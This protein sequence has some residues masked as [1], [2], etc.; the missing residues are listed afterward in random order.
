M[1]ESKVRKLTFFLKMVACTLSGALLLQSLLPAAPARAETID[2]PPGYKQ[3]ESG[4]HMT[5]ALD[6]AGGVWSW[7]WRP[8]GTDM[9]SN[10]RISYATPAPVRMEDGTPLTGIKQI[11]VGGGHTVA[12]GFDGRVWTWGENDYGQLGHGSFQDSYFARLVEFPDEAGDVTKVDA[13][14]YFSMALTSSTKVYSWGRNS[15]GQLGN[16][17]TADSNVPVPAELDQDDPLEGIADIAAGEDFALA[18]VE[19][20]V[21]GV[22][23]AWGDSSRGQL[24]TGASGYGVY[25]AYPM[26]VSGIGESVRSI[27]T[28]FAA[29]HSI[30]VADDGSIYGWGENADNQLT[31]ATASTYWFYTFP[32]PLPELEALQPSL[33]ATGYSHTLVVDQNGEIKGIGTNYSGELAHDSYYE[34]AYDPIVIPAMESS[35][36]SYLHAG[37]E[38][39]FIIYEGG[40]AHGFGDNNFNQIGPDELN[41]DSKIPSPVALEPLVSTGL[42][43]RARIV[44]YL[45]EAVL[46]CAGAYLYDSYSSDKRLGYAGSDG[47]CI[48]TDIPAGTAHELLH[49]AFG[50]YHEDYHT[51]TR[52]VGPLTGDVDLG[53]VYALPTFI[54]TNFEFY[55]EDSLSYGDSNPEVGRISGQLDWSA[56]SWSGDSLSYRAYFV[57]ASGTELEEV[58]TGLTFNRLELDD[59]PIPEGAVGLQLDVTVTGTSGAAGVY[60]LP[61]PFPIVDYPANVPS[62]QYN[63]TNGNEYDGYANEMNVQIAIDHPISIGGATKY[64]VVYRPFSEGSVEYVLGEVPFGTEPVTLSAGSWDIDHHLDRILIRIVDDQGAVGY[65]IELD[66]L[67]DNISAEPV[68]YTPAEL[69]T[70]VVSF[71]DTDA[72]PAIGGGVTWTFDD[73]ADTSSF[74]GYKLYFVDSAGERLS[75]GAPILK[76]FGGYKHYVTIPRGTA[77]PEGAAGIGVFP[78]TVSGEEPTVNA[79]FYE[80]E[81]P[82]PPEWEGPVTLPDWWFHDE[83]ER[84]GYVAGTFAI[85]TE[86]ITPEFAG[87]A[88][89]VVA[90]DEFG[91]PAGD[92]LISF[93]LSGTLFEAELTVPDGA[94]E[95]LFT[96]RSPDG[97]YYDGGELVVWGDY[98]TDLPAEGPGTVDP[99][100]P[101]AYDVSFADYDSDSGEIGGILTWNY[102]NYEPY[103]SPMG[104]VVYF[105]YDDGVTVTPKQS[106][107]QYSFPFGIE[108]LEAEVPFTAFIPTDTAVPEGANGIAVYMKHHVDYGEGEPYDAYSEPGS[109]ALVDF[110]G[111]EGEPIDLTG[112]FVDTDLTV[113]KIG[114]MVWWNAPAD[115]TGII[116]YDIYLADASQHMIGAPIATV[117]K[118]VSPYRQGIDTSID[119]AAYL[120]VRSNGGNAK[121]VLAIDDTTPSNSR[122]YEAFI[123][124][125]I[126]STEPLTLVELL[127]YARSHPEAF[128]T[129]DA[130]RI[131]LKLTDPRSGLEI[132]E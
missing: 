92:P 121:L 78:Y 10:H 1:G 124:G 2:T 18:L 117:P 103:Y 114:G 23:Y 49:N 107:L 67:F 54:P 25:S 109:G 113:G 123:R 131:L 64:Q 29:N 12:L 72:T 83:D 28:D 59:V 98:A 100:L 97:D 82:P 52:F 102:A 39:S 77:V 125:E 65:E 9:D 128:G 69:A 71:S 47:S 48:F 46:G 111:G 95:L 11:A 62:V 41:D 22:V 51:L 87:Y 44:N 34:T 17:N 36:V 94:A 24:G 91:D 33:I 32:E 129:A 57:D 84:V 27:H 31:D 55:S 76:T 127:Q 89:V 79:S 15:Q 19:E 14:A 8:L 26:E 80:F 42:Q 74:A 116:S 81:T 90:V 96:I 88:Y 93:P 70:P 16:R 53:T 4:Y 61:Y 56:S 68:S 58:A 50:D 40:L 45:T 20:T 37:Q 30:V 119:G 118:G 43:I 110:V 5:S 75:V 105:V 21:T 3:V 73:S 13:G 38:I 112:G 130:Y 60:T 115:E 132:S 35:A 6:T 66:A 101:V 108:A 86:T 63:D 104:Y 120:V 126:A 85:D 106:I 99:G 122:A 7:G